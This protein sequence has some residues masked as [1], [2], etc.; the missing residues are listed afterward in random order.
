[1]G[2]FTEVHSILLFL[3]G[4]IKGNPYVYRIPLKDSKIVAGTCE[5]LMNEIF[6]EW[7][8]ESNVATMKLSFN[9]YTLNEI[10]FDMPSVMLNISEDKPLHLFYRGDI[11]KTKKCE[12]YNSKGNH[13]LLLTNEYGNRFI[14]T[15]EINDL[16]FTVKYS[17]YEADCKQINV[18]C[19]MLALFAAV[20]IICICISEYRQEKIQRAKIAKEPELQSDQITEEAETSKKNPKVQFMLDQK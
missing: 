18:V 5:N 9:N 8:D 17:K 2:F 12:S 1:M 3:D 20:C 19:L 15:L 14:G 7:T 11:L 6:I 13:S 4:I 10:A 16:G